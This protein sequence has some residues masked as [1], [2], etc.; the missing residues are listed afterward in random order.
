[1]RS[2][3]NAG[4]SHADFARTRVGVGNELWNGLGRNRWIDLHDEWRADYARDR[5]DVADEIEVKF[6]IQR[7][8]D[9]GRRGGKQERITIRRRTN[10]CLGANIGPRAG[11]VFNDERLPEPLGQ[12]FP[13]YARDEVYVA[14]G[15]E[16]R[17]QTH[18]PRRIGLR[19]CDPRHGRERGSARGQMQKLSAGKFHRRLSVS[20]R[21]TRSPRRRGEQRRRHIEAENLRGLGV[22]DQLELGRLH[23]W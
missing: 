22:D 6:L 11:S 21:F 5:C 9:R 20:R 17:N 23:D 14:P 19:P 2:G 15:C 4:R 8:V 18:W 10:D 16:G 13:H 3:P 12:Q 1:M 7:R